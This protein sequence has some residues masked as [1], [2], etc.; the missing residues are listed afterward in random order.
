MERP[1]T[2]V[3]SSG[4]LFLLGLMA[5]SLITGISESA[6]VRRHAGSNT[7]DPVWRMVAGAQTASNYIFYEVSSSSFL[8][9]TT[10]DIGRHTTIV[11]TKLYS[12]K[13]II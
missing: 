12:H 7:T 4:A 1:T 9:Y 10:G 3:P 5:S 11:R 2:S 13:G 8:T 6:P